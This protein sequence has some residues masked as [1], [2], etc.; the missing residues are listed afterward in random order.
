MIPTKQPVD[1]FHL[2]STNR[3][4]NPWKIAGLK[5]MSEYGKTDWM[6]QDSRQ[7]TL[8]AQLQPMEG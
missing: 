5:I 4:H 1:S 7:L 8:L 6:K 3:L 2:I